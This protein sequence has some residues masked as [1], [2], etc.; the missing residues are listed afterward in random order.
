M[1]KKIVIVHSMIIIRIFPKM[2][3]VSYSTNND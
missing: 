3:S 1:K 2:I